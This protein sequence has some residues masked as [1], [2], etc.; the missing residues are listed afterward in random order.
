[1][2]S[3]RT[4]AKPKIPTSEIKFDEDDD[5]EALHND[6]LGK[7]SLLSPNNALSNMHNKRVSMPSDIESRFN[8]NKTQHTK[9]VSKNSYLKPSNSEFEH[10]SMGKS[11]SFDNIPIDMVNLQNEAFSK[12]FIDNTSTMQGGKTTKAQD[13]NE[14]F[15]KST[16]PR[17]KIPLELKQKFD[18]ISDNFNYNDEFWKPEDGK[19]H[20]ETT[21]IVDTQ[22][23]NTSK[24]NLPSSN[25]SK[26]PAA[27]SNARCNTSIPNKSIEDENRIG[28]IKS[29]WI[30]KIIKIKENIDKKCKCCNKIY[31][32]IERKPR[33]DTGNNA[34][35]INMG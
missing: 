30:D 16:Y 17:S 28:Y 2:K 29:D 11:D 12:M 23:L 34:T 21:K 6:A 14:F 9:M 25:M 19:K 15:K 24:V 4:L 22:R 33:L 5:D 8:K 18:L 35:D 26:L 13:I 31:C 27:K 20:P 1:M 32:N 7:F 10:E 3:V